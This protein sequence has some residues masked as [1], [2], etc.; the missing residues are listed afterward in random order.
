MITINYKLETVLIEELLKQENIK[1]LEKPSLL[2]KIGLKKP[3]FANIYFHNG[4]LDKEVLENI[5]N[6]KK[7][8]VNSFGAKKELLKNLDTIDD[9]IEV[10]YPAIKVAYEN[11]KEAKK[12][13]CEKLDIDINKRVVFFTAQNLKANGVDEF[14]NIIRKLNFKNMIAIIASNNK[15]QMY[16]LR[17]KLSKLNLNNRLILLEDCKNLDELFLAAD[18]FLLPTYNKNF[19]SNILKAM[20]CKCAV[21]TTYDNCAKELIDT[22]SLMRS[23]QDASIMFKIDALLQNKQDMKLIKKQNRKVAKE[24][25]LEKQLFKLHKIISSI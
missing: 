22:F 1:K 3:E 11:P 5:K 14:I 2:N 8:I 10:I 21:F 17:F 19:A 20:Y 7:V 15:Q 16:N 24:Y 13:L 4:V 23:P 6:A 25:T 18:V 12:K 9:K